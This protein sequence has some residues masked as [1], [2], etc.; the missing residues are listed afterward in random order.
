MVLGFFQRFEIKYIMKL[1]NNPPNVLGRKTAV[2]HRVD[3]IPPTSVVA[4]RLGHHSGQRRIKCHALFLLVLFFDFAPS[5]K[6]PG[7]PAIP[8]GN[9]LD[10][11]GYNLQPKSHRRCPLSKSGSRLA[12]QDDPLSGHDT[13]HPDIS[14]RFL[15]CFSSHSP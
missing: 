9:A 14:P 2:F 5:M 1:T 13:P 11:S 12:S 8:L 15:C 4:P 3:Y 6:Q 7:A 10:I